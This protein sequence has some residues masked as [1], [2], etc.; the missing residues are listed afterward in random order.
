MTGRELA[1]R[2]ASLRPTM[3]VLFM[4]GYAGEVI[5]QQGVVDSDVAFLSKPFTS[6]ALAQK[7]REL[8]ET[9]KPTS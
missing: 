9:A 8:L 4:S 6:V 5:A 2:L 7:L 3:K 1:V